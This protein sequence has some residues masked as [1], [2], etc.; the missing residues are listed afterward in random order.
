MTIY[1][2]WKISIYVADRKAATSCRPMLAKLLLIRCVNAAALPLV[3]NCSSAFPPSVASRVDYSMQRTEPLPVGTTQWFQLAEGWIIMMCS[4]DRARNWPCM[5]SIE[6]GPPDLPN[7]SR[8]TT[9]PQRRSAPQSLRCITLYIPIR[10]AVYWKWIMWA[11]V[12]GASVSLR[13]SCTRC[14]SP[15]SPSLLPKVLQ[16]KSWQMYNEPT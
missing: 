5:L 15:H 9:T 16:Y 8:L 12:R 14:L 4:N 13:G 11:D 7:S 6:P 1:L 2:T 3:H 10:W